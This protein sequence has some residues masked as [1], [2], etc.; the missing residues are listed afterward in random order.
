MMIRSDF[1]IKYVINEDSLLNSRENLFLLTESILFLSY[2][3]SLTL[4][5]LAPFLH[6]IIALISLL[7]SYLFFKILQVTIEHLRIMKD[8]LKQKYPYY[9]RIKDSLSKKVKRNLNKPG[10][11]NT[12]LGICLPII[13]MI[14]WVLCIGYSVFICREFFCDIVEKIQFILSLVG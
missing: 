9:K 4:L 3:T 2:I 6:F 11:V 8:E 12:W 7:T 1:L 13:V 14:I 10:R 5:D